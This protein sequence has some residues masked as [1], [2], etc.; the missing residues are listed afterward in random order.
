MVP[1]IFG[2]LFRYVGSRLITFFGMNPFAFEHYVEHQI[3]HFTNIY[4][5]TQKLI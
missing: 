1:R 5:T 3:H 2:K 4:P